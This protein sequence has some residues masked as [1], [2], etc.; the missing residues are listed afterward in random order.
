M[1]SCALDELRKY[2]EEGIDDTMPL[3]VEPTESESE[4]RNG[5]VQYTVESESNVVT[6]EGE[7]RDNFEND[8]TTVMIPRT[9]RAEVMRSI[10]I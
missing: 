2:A 5:E 8:A 3:K 10:E 6:A 9:H 4:V 7:M 1:T